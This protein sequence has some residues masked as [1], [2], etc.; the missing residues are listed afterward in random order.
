MTDFD[1][2]LPYNT[3]PDLP[4]LVDTIETTEILKSCI[5]SR[6]ALAELKQAALE[7]AHEH[8]HHGR[9]ANDEQQHLHDDLERQT[10]EEHR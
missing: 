8:H 3:L 1:P 10:E 6:V 4:P 2:K 9:K 5:K 7:I